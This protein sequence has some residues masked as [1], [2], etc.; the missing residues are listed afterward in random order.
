M[1]R[2]LKAVLEQEF[3]DDVEIIDRVD[4]GK[5]GNFEVRIQQTG[6]L[7]HSKTTRGQG[8][9]ESSAEQQQVIDAIKDYIDNA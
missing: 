6:D 8:R 7:V 2:G 9:C 5:T 3:G 1:F 4:D